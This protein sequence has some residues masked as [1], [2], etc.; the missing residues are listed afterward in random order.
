[1]GKKER[2][3]WFSSFSHSFLLAFSFFF[4]SFFKVIFFMY[5]SLICVCNNIL[6][7]DLENTQIK[8]ILFGFGAVYLYLAQAKA[9]QFKAKAIR[10]IGFQGVFCESLWN[11]CKRPQ[12]EMALYIGLFSY[13]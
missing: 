9:G 13:C 1:M 6:L 5:K 4:S 11:I 10:I 3:N 12:N 7:L 8:Y 2:G